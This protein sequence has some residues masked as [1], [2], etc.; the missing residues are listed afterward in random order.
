MNDREL[1]AFNDCMEAV[2]WYNANSR[3]NKVA[4]YMPRYEKMM[5]EIAGAY[6]ARTETLLN[7]EK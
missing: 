3:K 6:L 4:H 5:I 2:A 1:D 7:K